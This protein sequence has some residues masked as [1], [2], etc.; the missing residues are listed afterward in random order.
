ME[1]DVA[2]GY[3]TRHDRRARR[4]EA[5]TARILAK[6]AH[7]SRGVNLALRFQQRF[8][9][10]LEALGKKFGTTPLI[11]RLRPESADED[12]PADSPR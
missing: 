12:R 4:A 10:D 6:L 7:V 8:D 5:N 1:G 9:F 3:R 2:K 11:R